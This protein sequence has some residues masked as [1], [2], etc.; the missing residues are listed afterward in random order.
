MCHA[1]IRTTIK[2]RMNAEADDVAA[3]PRRGFTG[4]RNANLDTIGLDE[5]KKA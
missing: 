5:P 4:Q 3:E 1:G 2:Y